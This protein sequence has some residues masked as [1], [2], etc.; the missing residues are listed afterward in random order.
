[1]LS[2]DGQRVR[3]G[4][5]LDHLIR[6]G[7]HRGSNVHPAQ[8]RRVRSTAPRRPR[9]RCAWRRVLHRTGQRKVL[10]T[11]IDLGILAG[12][13]RRRRI[14][15]GIAHSHGD[16][17]GGFVE[18]AIRC[19]DIYI[20]L[21]PGNV[22][23]H[24]KHGSENVRS[25]QERY[26][27]LA[28]SPH[29][30]WSRI[31]PARKPIA[32][33]GN[34]IVPLVYFI[35]IIPASKEYQIIGKQTYFYVY[36]GGMRLSYR[37][38]ERILV[39]LVFAHLLRHVEHRIANVRS[40][41]ERHSLLASCP[42]IRWSA[43]G[44]PARRFAIQNKIARLCITSIELPY[45]AIAVTCHLKIKRSGAAHRRG[46]VRSNLPNSLN[47]RF[48]AARDRDAH[49]SP[50]RALDSRSRRC[51]ARNVMVLFAC[52]AGRSRKQRRRNV[53]RIQELHARTP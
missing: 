26:G 10:R 13:N 27:L 9:I 38:H 42:C 11:L 36:R 25:A 50:R 2:R 39:G 22:I 35:G 15:I 51:H 5:C 48:L 17:A 32:V 24:V 44:R 14:G 53:R 23:R 12:D 19:K 33:Y 45:S 18:G 7:E 31:R 46:T 37:R 21:I 16:G 4:C 40:A 49:P 3:V 52:A 29:I 28:T 41:Q 1:M 47:G 20:N 8:K 43:P 6:H 30:Y 34:I